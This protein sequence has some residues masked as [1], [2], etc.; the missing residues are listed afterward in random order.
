MAKLVYPMVAAN[1]TT[2]QLAA[3]SKAVPSASSHTVAEYWYEDMC[4]TV[5]WDR[6]SDTRTIEYMFTV[7]QIVEGSG[8][9]VET[10]TPVPPYM[11]FPR[12]Q[13]HGSTCWYRASMTTLSVPGGS[14]SRS[15]DSHSIQVEHLYGQDGTC[16]VRLHVP[17]H[18]GTDAA[19]SAFRDASHM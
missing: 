18:V 8:A 10:R 9:Y 11:R 5:R 14:G 16:T 15:G 12:Y 13:Y 19:L 3:A 7:G 4:T 17:D 6:A 2:F 1:G